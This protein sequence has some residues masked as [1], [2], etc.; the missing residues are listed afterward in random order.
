LLISVSGI[1]KTGRKNL[2]I[3]F[4]ISLV[5]VVI[6]ELIATNLPHNNMDSMVSWTNDTGDM[7]DLIVNDY[8]IPL[9]GA[10]LFYFVQVV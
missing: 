1:R 9:L 2:L 6:V 7:P 3:P 5:A 4:W 10:F 8:E